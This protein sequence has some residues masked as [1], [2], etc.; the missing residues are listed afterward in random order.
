MPQIDKMQEL[1]IDTV[2]LEALKRVFLN[3][4]CT[5][6]LEALKRVF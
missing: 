6:S 2:P 4:V 5:Y 1:G 3:L